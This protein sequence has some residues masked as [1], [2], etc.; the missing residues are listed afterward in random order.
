M[1]KIYLVITE[2]MFE[3]QK[4]PIKISAFKNK[5]IAKDV[6][7]SIVNEK[8]QE[9]SEDYISEDYETDETEDCFEAWKDNYYLED[10]F[11]CYIKEVELK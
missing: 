4:E 10:N 6:M 5:D 9:I 8:K 2:G 3:Y 7:K 1:A 11:A